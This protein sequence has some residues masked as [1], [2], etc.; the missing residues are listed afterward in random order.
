MRNPSK[1]LHEE[2]SEQ[3]IGA[4]IVVLNA[5]G[6]G[7]D[8]KIYER[9]LII[10]L[11]ERGLDVDSQH[12]F[13]VHFKGHL[14]GSLI[15]DL[16]VGGKV[17]VDT[18]VVE[19]F[20]DRRLAKVLAHLAITGLELGL[21]INFKFPRLQWKRVVRSSTALRSEALNQRTENTA[22]DVDARG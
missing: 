3:L 11:V 6:P 21:L 18:K 22:D 16:I 2:L 7:L 19:S 20:H 5:L 14:V 10:E 15:P 8:E 12:E 13:P 17:I 4:A 9:A 1:L